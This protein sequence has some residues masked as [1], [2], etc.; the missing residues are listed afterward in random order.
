MEKLLIKKRIGLIRILTV[1]CLVLGITFS[2]APSVNATGG[3]SSPVETIG[4]GDEQAELTHLLFAKLVYDYLDGYQGKTVEEYV[5]D[6]SKLYAEEIWEDSGVTYQQLYNSVIGDWEIYNICNHNKT[7]GFYAVAFKKDEKV[8]IAYRGSEMFTDEFALDE[9]NDWTGTDFKFALFNELSTQ[10]EDADAFYRIVECNLA[11]EGHKEDGLD[12]T[13]TGH[14]LGGALCAYE[15]L[16]SGCYGYSFDGACGHIIDLTY[17][18]G[19]LDIDDFTGTDD[20]DNIPFVNYTDTTGYEVA[21]LIQHTYADYM[22]Q[23]DRE[24]N[25]DNLNEYTL[26]PKTAD[27]GSHIIWSTLKAEDGRVI[28]TDKVDAGTNGFTYEPYGPVYLDITKNVIEAGME[29]VNFDTPWNIIDMRIL[30]ISSW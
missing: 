11:M 30:I 12:I 10:F 24:T 23:V 27:A 28:F 29:N 1:L 22:Y 3:M 14:S 20:L 19:Y 25:L 21:D 26:I 5:N 8:I 4:D 16:K 18:Y 9:S 17:Y 7:T 6:N 2:Y 13:L 15:S